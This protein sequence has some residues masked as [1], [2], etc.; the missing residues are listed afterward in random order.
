MSRK[1]FKLL[2]IL[3]MAGLLIACSSSNN[4]VEG[5]SNEINDNNDV[6]QEEVTLIW[7]TENQ[8]RYEDAKEA[9]EDEFPHITIEFYNMQSSRESIQEML[10]GQIYPDIFDTFSAH[11][12][13]KYMESQITYDMDELVDKHGFDLSRIEPSILSRIRSYALDQELYVFPYDP[14]LLALFYNKSI[15]DLFG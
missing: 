6:D 10:A 8:V 12:L 9:I 4:N 3:L 5:R 7:A 11:Q 1:T 2:A 14:D 13:P 15:F